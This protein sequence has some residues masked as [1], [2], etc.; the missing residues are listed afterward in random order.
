M[1][2]MIKSKR[3]R[4]AGQVVCMGEMINAY[5]VLVGKLEGKRPLRTPRHRREDNIK[6]ELGE[7]ELKGVDWIN[8]AQDRDWLQALVNMVMNLWVPWMARNFLIR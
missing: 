4:W 6:M 3:M 1:I 2:R 8:L 7:I 5:K